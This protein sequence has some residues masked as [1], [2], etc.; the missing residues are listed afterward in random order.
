MIKFELVMANK[1]LNEINQALLRSEG[2]IEGL[3]K[4]VLE[5]ESKVIEYDT[6]KII[7]EKE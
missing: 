7:F 2:I 1:L 3:T 6:K 4:K 5:L